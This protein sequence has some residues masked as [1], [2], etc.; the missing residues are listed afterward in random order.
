MTENQWVPTGRTGAIVSNQF[1]QAHLLL[2]STVTQS[3][4]QVLDVYY[5]LKWIYP[6][7]MSNVSAAN[8]RKLARKACN[9]GGETGITST[10]FNWSTKLGTPLVNF[11]TFE[12]INTICDL[13]GQ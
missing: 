5:R 11:N 1:M 2:D 10:Y 7:T 4:T 9:V 8:L 13:H 3:T 6:S 12:Y